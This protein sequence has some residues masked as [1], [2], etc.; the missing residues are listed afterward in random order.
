[1]GLGDGVE[2]G[3]GI[4]EIGDCG[5]W[6]GLAPNLAKTPCSLPR[7]LQNAAVLER[8]MGWRSHYNTL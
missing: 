8:F 6:K 7:G 5:L 4:S 1:M 2:L 3:A